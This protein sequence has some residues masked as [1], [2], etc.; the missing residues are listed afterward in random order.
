VAVVLEVAVSPEVASEAVVAE[1]GKGDDVIW[2]IIL[3]A[4]LLKGWL[5]KGELRRGKIDAG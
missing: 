2:G 3:K 1:V 4:I 5:F